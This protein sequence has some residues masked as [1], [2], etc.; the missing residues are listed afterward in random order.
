MLRNLESDTR[1]RAVQVREDRALDHRA[2]D[3][4]LTAVIQRGPR[5]FQIYIYNDE[6][7]LD[8]D[9][10]WH[11]FE[12]ADWNGSSEDLLEGYLEFLRKEIGAYGEIAR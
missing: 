7:G 12:L 4:Y 10:T 9:G 1:L 5:R 11:G 2:N 6:A 8:V 3:V